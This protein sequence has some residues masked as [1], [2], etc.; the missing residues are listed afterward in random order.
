MVHRLHIFVFESSL[1]SFI[2]R[3]L[4]G[5][6]YCNVNLIGGVQVSSKAVESVSH[7]MRD[8]IVRRRKYGRYRA[9]VCEAGREVRYVNG[10]A[11]GRREDSRME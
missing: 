7:N 10:E 1:S 8:V 11:G 6:T 5:N 4:K 3:I 9:G 2:S